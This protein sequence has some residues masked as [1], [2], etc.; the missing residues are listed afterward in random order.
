MASINLGK[1]APTP[2]GTWNNTNEYEKLDIVTYD[3]KHKVYIALKNVPVGINITNT[4]YWE[5]LIDV[6]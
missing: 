6:S 1:I 2:K 3:N 5:N 4:E